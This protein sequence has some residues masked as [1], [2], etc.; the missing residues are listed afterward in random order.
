VP[1]DLIDVNVIKLVMMK[2]LE[3]VSFTA[4]RDASEHMHLRCV[5]GL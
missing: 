3:W 2:R 1:S 5:D 4:L